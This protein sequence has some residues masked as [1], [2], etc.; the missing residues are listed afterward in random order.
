MS[1]EL[2]WKQR[3]ELSRDKAEAAEARNA[4]LSLG[5]ADALH[6]ARVSIELSE[7]ATGY[8]SDL[9]ARMEKLWGVLDKENHENPWK[10]RN[11]ALAEGLREACEALEESAGYQPDHTSRL[12]ALLAAGPTE[13]A[14]ELAGLRALRGVGRE[15][16]AAANR[17][18]ID[19]AFGPP[20][21]LITSPEIA[22]KLA[23]GLRAAGPADVEAIRGID[24]EDLERLERQAQLGFAISAE[25]A[26]RMAS[27]IRDYRRQVNDYI[28][29]LNDTRS[30]A[31]RELSEAGGRYRET[32]LK[33]LEERDAARAELAEE[34]AAHETTATALRAL[35]DDIKCDTYAATGGLDGCPSPAERVRLVCAQLTEARAIWCE[36]GHTFDDHREAGMLGD[37]VCAAIG[38]SCGNFTTATPEDMI[39]AVWRV[40]GAKPTENVLDY[41]RRLQK[42]EAAILAL[43]DL[44]PGAPAPEDAQGDAFLLADNWR[45]AAYV[46]EKQ[47]LR[48]KGERDAA[49]ARMAELEAE[50]AALRGAK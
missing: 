25:I 12:R 14:E 5:F 20:D 37:V 24:D 33:A 42:Q 34:R 10:A 19:A 32:V 22:R 2:N 40:L 16:G 30:K 11:A 8:P 36:C 1:A 3:Y 7:K 38:C 27:E 26:L 29:V 41:V 43:R 50:L 45:G 35:C 6:L 49:I 39:A 4:T 46:N 15:I 23:Q 31:D 47:Y 9:R 28:E 44:P 48:A 18:A 17:K 13:A 21:Q